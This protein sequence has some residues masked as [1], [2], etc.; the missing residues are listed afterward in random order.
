[1]AS[2]DNTDS[3]VYS[4]VQDYYGKVLES[5]SDLKTNACTAGTKPTP[6][7]CKIISTIP[8]AV[9]DKFYGCGNPIPLGIQGLDLLDLGSGSGRDCYLAASLV[10]PRGSVTGVDMTDEQ[11]QTARENIEEYAKTLGYK[12]NMRFLTGY[13]EDLK[14]TG[15]SDLSVD[16]CISN[17]VVNM[18]PDKKS[19]FKGVYDALREGGEFHFSDMYADARVSSEARKHKILISEGMGG[20]LYVEDFE[21]IAKEEIGFVQ[22]RV[23]AISHIRVYDQQLQS[24]VGDTKF[25]SIT[26]RLFKLPENNSESEN[27]TQSVVYNGLIDGQPDRYV[28][29][30]NNTFNHDEPC[31]VDPD[32]LKILKH[33]WLSKYFS[34]VPAQKDNCGSESAK[35]TARVSTTELMR[36]AYEKSEK[37]CCGSKPSSCQ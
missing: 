29:D 10:G 4:S 28:L 31:V 25:Y 2:L 17:C 6:Y 15:V 23:L 1:M 24:M 18:S 32:T 21:R 20:S 14:Q 37:K 11:L 19:V 9:N 7:L 12:P 30:I 34:F 26:Y 5:S 27:L 33:S 36:E 35:Q 22:P 3:Q 8:K 16:I 13:I